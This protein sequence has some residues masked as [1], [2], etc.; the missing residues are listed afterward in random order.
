M[1]VFNSL[2]PFPSF[3]PSQLKQS[4]N[5]AHSAACDQWL[6][7]N[8][9]AIEANLV[10]TGCRL[11]APQAS[12]EKQ[13]IWIGLEPQMLLTPF[14]EIRWMLEKLAPKAGDRIVD[15]GAAYGRMGFVLARH[16]A[17]CE[18]VGYE[19][20]GERVQDGKKAL[21]RFGASRARLEHADLTSDDFKIPDAQIYFIYDFGTPKAIEKILY[22]LRRSGNPEARIV[23]RG[24]HCRYLIEQNHSWLVNAFPQE[25]ERRL[26]I[27]AYRNSSRVNHQSQSDSGRL[28]G[29]L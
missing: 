21:A 19:Y 25:P 8:V 1:L 2:D 9:N 7:L 17:K 23:C 29:Q 22:R 3:D 11:R 26:T 14:S 28:S 16:F 15:F 4:E 20:V 12:G 24:R 10:K 13:L 27:Y 5:F 18:F 6:G